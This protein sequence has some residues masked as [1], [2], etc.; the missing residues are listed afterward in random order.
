VIPIALS[1]V[2][3][4]IPECKRIAG[5]IREPPERITS[6]E[7]VILCIEASQYIMSMDDGENEIRIIPPASWVN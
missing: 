1:S 7:A 4:P 3:L 5:V 6:F 2:P